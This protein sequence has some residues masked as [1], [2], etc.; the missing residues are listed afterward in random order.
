MVPE[1]QEGVG[2]S[3]LPTGHVGVGHPVLG[4]PGVTG[5]REEGDEAVNEAVQLRGTGRSALGLPTAST[6]PHWVFYPPLQGPG[7]FPKPQGP[8]LVPKGPRGDPEK[9]V[10]QGL[11]GPEFSATSTH[12]ACNL[13][14]HPERGPQGQGQNDLVWERPRFYTHIPSAAPNT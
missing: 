3:Q 7:R 9:R 1:Q 12:G 10:P 5:V 14:L 13:A 11:G 6:P 8:G 4:R 2:H